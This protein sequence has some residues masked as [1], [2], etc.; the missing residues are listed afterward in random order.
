LLRF[1]QECHGKFVPSLATV[2][3]GVNNRRVARSRKR[4]ALVG[5]GATC[6]LRR[7]GQSYSRDGRR[8]RKSC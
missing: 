1:T 4:I 8:V 3:I 2:G 6:A 5:R 7:W